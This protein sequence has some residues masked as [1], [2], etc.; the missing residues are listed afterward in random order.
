MCPRWRVCELRWNP[1]DEVLSF[2]ELISALRLLAFFYVRSINEMSLPAN[3]HDATFSRVKYRSRRDSCH[4]S[5]AYP[6]QQRRHQ[7][8]SNRHQGIILN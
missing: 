4:V 1:G 3:K 6:K 2:G 7:H 5:E 8:Y